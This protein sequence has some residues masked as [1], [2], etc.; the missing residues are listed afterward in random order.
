MKTLIFTRKVIEVAHDVSHSA[1]VWHVDGLN[2]PR[3]GHKR[4][5]R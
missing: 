2:G 4:H 3:G 1:K 5:A